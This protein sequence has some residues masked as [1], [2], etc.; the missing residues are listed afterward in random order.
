VVVVVV[1]VV[2]SGRMCKQG[3]WATGEKAR[4]WG[5]ANVPEMSGC[6]CSV[7]G[8]LSWRRRSQG[9]RDQEE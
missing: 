9:R 8:M 2:V 1:V 3:T 6:R 7:K 4:H 5:W